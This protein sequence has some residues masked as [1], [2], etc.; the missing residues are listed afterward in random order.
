QHADLAAAAQRLGEGARHDDIAAV[1]EAAE[2][3]RIAGK[4]PVGIDRQ[5]RHYR[6]PPL[7]PA[8]WPAPL[9][10]AGVAARPPL[11]AVVTSEPARCQ[12]NCRKT[13]VAS[14]R[15]AAFCL[16][17]I[18]LV[19]SPEEL[20]Q[21]GDLAYEVVEAPV[22]GGQ[23]AQRPDQ[24]RAGTT[25]PEEQC[26]VREIAPRRDGASEFVHD[27][28]LEGWASGPSAARIAGGRCP[29]RRCRLPA[30]P[31]RARSGQT[32]RAGKP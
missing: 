30:L 27:D 14:W 8:L 16:V 19:L 18:D 1:I 7:L 3:A 20:I 26:E 32:I 23:L 6:L 2:E 29:C 31:T 17:G 25:G 12:A 9:A 24:Q 4:P 15:A 21:G 10:G 5:G 11:P 28:V 22:G 13:S